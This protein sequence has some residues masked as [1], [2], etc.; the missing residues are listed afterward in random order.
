MK[1]GDR[2][3]SIYF[4]L[5]DLLDT[6]SELGIE[7]R[8]EELD[9]KYQE[10]L[11]IIKLMNELKIE[12]ILKY[13]NFHFLRYYSPSK[14]KFLEELVSIYEQNTVDGGKLNLS[15]IVTEAKSRAL[16]YEKPIQA[17]SFLPKIEATSI[18]SRLP[19]RPQSSK[20]STSGIPKL[21]FI[22]SKPQRP[23]SS[24]Q[25]STARGQT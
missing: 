23:S 22:A 2:A 20:P 24:A 16:Q 3:E 9:E 12:L 7:R 6:V 17:K 4:H 1:S 10:A 11:D 21:R 5:Q 19:D 15:A 18:K 13:P 14:A 8:Y 25:I